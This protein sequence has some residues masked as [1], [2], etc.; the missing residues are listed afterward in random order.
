MKK[1]TMRMKRTTATTEK[2]PRRTL[3]V[4]EAA[5]VAMNRIA[6]SNPDKSRKELAS[7]IILEAVK[8]YK[9]RKPP[10]KGKTK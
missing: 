10:K 5:Y 1:E 8:A 6:A 7:E 2:L 4:T 3:D 9:G